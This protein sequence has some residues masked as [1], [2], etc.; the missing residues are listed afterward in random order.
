MLRASCACTDV[1]QWAEHPTRRKQ[2]ECL[3]V[4]ETKQRSSSGSAIRPGLSLRQYCP[5]A[6]GDLVAA[7]CCKV[8]GSPSCRLQAVPNVCAPGVEDAAA[9]MAC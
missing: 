3:D 8:Q 5:L 7:R 2:D 4:G 9:R 1:V 6:L